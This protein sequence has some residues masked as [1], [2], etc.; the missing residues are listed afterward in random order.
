M[1]YGAELAWRYYRPD[2]PGNVVHGVCSQDDPMGYYREIER[3][4]GAPRF[5]LIMGQSFYAEY[6]LLTDYMEL[7]A[8]RLDRRALLF[9][10]SAQTAQA[11]PP[12]GYT[13]L[14]MP[15]PNTSCSG[16]FRFG[17]AAS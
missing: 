6:K 5:W 12:G 2:L 9:D 3:L 7:N 14:M 10:F 15:N 11:M 13:P 16:I 1:Y 4:R 8:T 17:R